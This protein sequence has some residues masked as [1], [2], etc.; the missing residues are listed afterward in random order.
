MAKYSSSTKA[1]N[2]PNDTIVGNH[3]CNPFLLFISIVEP[4]SASAADVPAGGE[5]AVVCVLRA[6]TLLEC[7]EDD[8]PS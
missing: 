5:Y 7:R 3:L 4:E 8:I 2:G 6:D 1:A